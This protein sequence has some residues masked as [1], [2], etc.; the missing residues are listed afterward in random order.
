MFSCLVTD[1]DTMTFKDAL[2]QDDRS[3]FLLA[4]SKELHDHISRNH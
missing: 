2:Q 3:H 4:M 1:A